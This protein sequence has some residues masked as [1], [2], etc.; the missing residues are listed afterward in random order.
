MIIENKKIKYYLAEET[1]MSLPVYCIAF[2][3]HANIVI[4]IVLSMLFRMPIDIAA[5]SNHPTMQA[6]PRILVTLAC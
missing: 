1:L 4:L 2:A 6:Q 5:T 3:V